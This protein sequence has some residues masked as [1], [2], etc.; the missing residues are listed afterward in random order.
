[1]SVTVV[2]AYGKDYKKLSEAKADWEKGVDFKV[3]DMSSEWNGY[4]CS[5]RNYRYNEVWVRFNRRQLKGRLQ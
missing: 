5:I 1:M 3:S 2:P 4:Y